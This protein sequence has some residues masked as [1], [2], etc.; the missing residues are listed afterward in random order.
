MKS[1]RDRNITCDTYTNY[2]YE[3]LIYVKVNLR[4][5]FYPWVTKEE[6]EIFNTIE[7]NVKKWNHNFVTAA[8]SRTLSD[9]PSFDEFID[10][11]SEEVLKLSEILKK[12]IEKNNSLGNTFS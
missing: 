2:C 5:Q 11:L 7:S 8:N 3:L 6:M 10:Q 12:E 4:L 1:D 9:I